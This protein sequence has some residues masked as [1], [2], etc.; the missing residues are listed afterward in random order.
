MSL[1]E[2]TGVLSFN[3]DGQ[4]NITIDFWSRDEHGGESND[5]KFT[6]SFVWYSS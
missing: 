2:A 3:N 5:Q 6:V 4:D 1:D